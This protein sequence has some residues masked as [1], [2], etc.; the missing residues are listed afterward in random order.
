MAHS[1]GRVVC[2]FWDEYLRQL[3]AAVVSQPNVRLVCSADL[4]DEA[5]DSVALA[6]SRGGEAELARDLLQQA[7]DRLTLG[8]R[9]LA[10]IDNPRDQWLHGELHKLAD[11][12]TRRPTETG[13]L[14]LLTKRRELAKRKKFAAAF[15]V[16]DR[17]RELFLR[18]R[19]GVFSH[20]ELD[21]G[22][23]ALV[24]AMQTEQ[25]RRVLDLGCGCGIAGLVAAA[26]AEQTAVLAIDSQARSVEATQ[27]GA[28][29]NQLPQV[30]AVLNADGTAA[31]R[32]TFD[33]VLANPPYYSRDRLPEFFV[34]TA[35]RALVR[36][37]V[38]WLV[39]KRPEW[40][41]E[42]M[43][44]LFREVELLPIRSYFVA[45]GVK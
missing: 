17:G 10:A 9:M 11:K 28:E 5:F 29:R 2:H 31:E 12:V 39:T 34:T 45:R 25:A 22:A 15:S 14:Y 30:T 6:L 21:G 27:W 8:G 4:P 26:R 7:Y 3:T 36:G 19:P 32:D 23:R 37:G 16:F 13:C 41:A 1:Q 20:R 40:Y 24:E 43:P 44:Q 33:V 18:T 38:L 42:R 35:H